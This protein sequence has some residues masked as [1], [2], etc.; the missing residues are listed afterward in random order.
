MHRFQLVIAAILSACAVTP[1]ANADVRWSIGLNLGPP[2]VYRPR[3]HYHPYPYRYVRP[4]YIEP[5][6]VIVRPAPIVYEPA[7]IVVPAPTGAVSSRSETR[8][9]A[10][11][12][13]SA[14]QR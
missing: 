12:K 11:E 13:P 4:Y 10:A 5:A 9:V 1:Y 14:I 3:Y 7:P 8:N 6:P 2:A